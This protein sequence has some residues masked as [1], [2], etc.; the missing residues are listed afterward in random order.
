MTLESVPAFALHAV[1]G[2]RAARRRASRASTSCMTGNDHVEFYWF[3][4]TDARLTKR[5][6]RVPLERRLAP[7]PGWRA[8]WDDELLSNAAFAGW[9]AAGRAVPAAD[10][11]ARPAVAAGAA[12]RAPTPTLAHRVFVSRAPGAVPRDGVRRPARGRSG[13]CWP[14]CARSSSANDWRIAFPVEVRVAPAD[15]IW[16]STAYG[17]DTAY[18][19][20]HVSRGHGPD[21]PYFAA[22]EAIARQ[23]GGR[24]HW[25][26][27]HSLD[28]AVLRGR[29]IRA[30]TSSPRVRDRLDP[31]RVF[32]NDHVRHVLGD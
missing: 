13:R 21:G 12:A 1:E 22:V 2:P 27:L 3:P 29:G 28:A 9:S 15:D 4:H 19:A 24:P 18:I 7:L 32:S 5:N 6:T 20:V 23:V 10:P 31:E 16:L 30:S 8:V 26:K 14:S 17:R 11:A 25:G